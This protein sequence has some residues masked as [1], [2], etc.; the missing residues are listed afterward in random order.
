MSAA[1]AV[2]FPKWVL[3]EPYVF[4]RDDD[5]SFPDDIDALFRASGTTSWGADFRIA[6]SLTDPPSISHLYA[7]LPGFPGPDEQ[8]P[9]EMVATHRHLSLLCVGTQTPSGVVQNFFIFRA[10]EN[11]PSS[12]SLTALPPCTVPRRYGYS[13]IRPGRPP[14]NA[15]P[16]LLDT[17]S[18]GLW[19]GDKEE[20]VVAELT[21][22]SFPTLAGCGRTKAFANICSLRSSFTDDQLAPCKWHTM[23]VPILSTTDD[24]LLKLA[25]WQTDTVI[26][27]QRWLCWI[28]YHQGILFWDVSEKADISFLWFPPDK[29]S[30]ASTHTTPCSGN[31]AVS[32]VD[33]G[34]LLK[35]VYV[36]R[37]DGC[38]AY[39]APKPGTGFAI[40]CYTLVLGGSVKWKEDYTVTS[41]D[42]PD[43]H[44]HRGL[45]LFPR[46]DIVRPQVVHSLFIEFGK[47]YEKMSVLSINMS[48][49][50]VESFYP[51]MDGNEL[52]QPGPTTV[53]ID[54]IRT[55]SMYGIPAPFLPCEF[56]SWFRYCSRF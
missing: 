40:T 41:D 17:I 51:Y 52:L 11:K 8:E 9:L 48:T 34:R 18:S 46:V 3:L 37:Q 32:V 50:T 29:Y 36:A 33:D 49:K 45:P 42:L 19:C 53:D 7:H 56:P 2:G 16:H 54:F 22:I 38:L 1:A 39:G 30:L 5:K 28:D 10:D 24:D 35:F 4:R 15:T 44:L 47:L 27:F 26:P 20:F 13:R 55:K 23:R 21:T 6:F 43:H 25:H 12:S 14:S 31:G